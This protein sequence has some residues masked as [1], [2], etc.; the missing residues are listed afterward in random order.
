M[1]STPHDADDLLGALAAGALPDDD[2]HAGHDHGPTADLSVRPA[3]PEDAALITGLQ[4]GA[5]RA[6]GIITE[7]ELGAVDTSAVTA[8]WQAA[9]T[10]PP[11]QRHRVLTACAGVEVVGFL[12]FAPSEGVALPEGAGDAPVEVLAL[13]VEA[14]HTREGHGS[15]LLAACADL[16][17]E[18][19]A[20]SLVVWAGQ[21]DDART[22]FLSSAGFA[23]AG[24]RRVLTTGA[25]DVVES[26]WFAQV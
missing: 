16:A 21:E 3:V 19:G 1:D 9:V 14:S 25:G 6:R 26:C 10:A 17:D 23:P 20:T 4:L 22:R 2:P 13:E 7:E 12:A 5:W 11:S 24:P 18:A 15:R 8:Q